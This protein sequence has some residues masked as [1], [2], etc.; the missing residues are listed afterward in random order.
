[1]ETITE[2]TEFRSGD[3]LWEWVI[4]SNPLPGALLDELDLSGDERASVRQALEG[5]VR[6][7]AGRQRSGAP[8][9]PGQHRH[10]HQVTRPPTEWLGPLWAALTI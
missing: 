5:L 4:C 8:D 6:S 1:M 7:R 3:E 10:R 9:Q 2:T